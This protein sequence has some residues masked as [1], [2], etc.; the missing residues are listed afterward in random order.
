MCGLDPFADAM[1]GSL[2][3]EQKKRTTIGVEL[4][5]KVKYELP[6]KAF[7][8]PNSLPSGSPNSCF[9]WT[10]QHP[11]WIRKV[12]GLSWLSFEILLITARQFYARGQCSSLNHNLFPK[13]SHRIHQPSA[14][15]FSVS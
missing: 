7:V 9:F 13:I 4:A 8:L 14:E 11:V 1:V 5:A 15:L 3:V 10:S 6:L 2:G 12:P